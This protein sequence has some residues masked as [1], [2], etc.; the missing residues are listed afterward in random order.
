MRSQEML[1][2]DSLAILRL[3]KLI[4]LRIIAFKNHTITYGYPH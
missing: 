1:N 2:E 3:G 4:L